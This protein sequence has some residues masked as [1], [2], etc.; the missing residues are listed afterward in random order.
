MSEE[1]INSTVQESPV[2]VIP[3]D[4]GEILEVRRYTPQEIAASGKWYD[5]RYFG[6]PSYSNSLVQVVM[7]SFV[8]F[9]C[10]GCFNAITGLG[11]LVFPMQS[12]LII[13]ILRCT[14]H[15]VSGF[16][17]GLPSINWVQRS[18]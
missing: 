8:L 9:L 15:S 1:K 6:L 18:V 11:V 10:P 14:V 2:E 5:Q 13:K 12:L 4:D 17:L 7:L 3:E 16:I